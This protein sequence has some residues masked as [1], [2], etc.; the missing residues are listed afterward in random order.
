MADSTITHY[1]RKAK[2]YEQKWRSYLE[3]THQVLLNHMH[4]HQSD[5]ILD[6]SGGT[7]LLAR[8]LIA[9]NYLFEHFVINDPAE[10]MLA[11][12]RERISEEHPISYETYNVQELS[13]PKNYFSKIICLN[14]FHFY[15][16]QQEVL[17]LFNSFLKPGGKLYILDWNRE[18]F[19]SF[20]NTVIQWSSPEYI[21]TRTL[22][23][24]QEMLSDT[25]FDIKTC[26]CWNWRY[27]KFM[28]VEAVK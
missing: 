16:N 1:N 8:K 15:K 28:F 12:A 24:L 13:F 23:E 21:N 4:I 25:T 5:I 17:N 27:W 9:Q 6:A 20:I 10:E 11:I 3:H 2:N 19:F 7:G 26:S 22:D 18:G 14:S